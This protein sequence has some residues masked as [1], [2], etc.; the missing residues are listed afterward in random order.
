MNKIFLLTVACMLSFMLHAQFR[1]ISGTVTGSDDGQPLL[2]VTVVIEGT[3]SGVITDIDGKYSISTPAEGSV[4][5]FSYIGYETQKIKA[6][7]ANTVD[8]VLQASLQILEDVVVVGYGTE[9]K[10]QVTGS[11]TQVGAEDIELRPVSTVEQALQGKAA[12]VFIEANN[13]K[14]GSAMRIRIRGSSSINASNQPLFVVDGVPIN[15]NSVN[16]GVYVYLN[17]LNDIDFN[18]IESID[19]LKDAS[20]AAIYGSRG[21]NGVV[22]ITTKRG[23]AGKPKIT[24]DYQQ[25][26]SKPTRLREFMNGQQYI[27]Y[28]LQAAE[29]AGVYDFANNISGYDTEEEAIDKY[30]NTIEK[31]LD[32][33]TAGSDWMNGDFENV[34]WQQYAFQD[35]QSKTLDVSFSG[36]S[37]NFQYFTSYGYSF[38]D[39]IML[40]NHGDRLS[41]SL[42]LDARLTDKL[43]IG[44]SL[45]IARSIN[46]DIPDDNSFQTPLQIVAEPAI[47]PLFDT[48]TGDYTDVP[49]ALYSNPLLDYQY[50]T[51]I[52]T[53]YRTIGNVFAEYALFPSLSLRGEAGADI[54]NLTQFYYTS[55]KSS[56][57][58]SIGGLGESW[59][60]RVE[61]FDTKLLLIYN[62]LFDSAYSLNVTG[63]IEYQ[64]YDDFTT[65]VEGSGFP[66]DKL[67]TL[68]SA[69]TITTGYSAF[70]YYRFL[71]YIGRANFGIRDKY[72]FTFTGRFDGSSRFGQNNRYGFFPSGS[73]GWIISNEDFMKDSKYLSFLK[74]RA[75]YGTTGNAEIGNF[76]YLGLYGAGSYG[77]ESSLYPSTIANPDL[78]WEKTTQGNIGI[79]FGFFKDR[80]S[81]EIDIYN[82]NT[83]DLLLDV[84]VPSTSGYTLQTQNIG[85]LNNKGIE[86]VINGD[87]FTGAFTWNA[88]LNFAKNKNEVLELANGQ[89]IIDFG[90]SDFLNVVLVG[91]PIGV[92]YGAEYAGVDPDN[93][94]ALWYVN[95]DGTGEETTNDFIMANYVVVGDPNPDFI[96]GMTNTLTYK[97]ID[98][99]LDLQSVYGNDVNLQGDYWMSANASQYDNQ[100]V[101]Q[102]EAWQEPG[103]ITDVPENRL[104]FEN[105]TQ[106]RSSR[107][108]SD[109]SYLRLKTLTLG[110]TLPKT[111]TNK[112]KMGGLRLYASSYNL[113]T[114]TNYRG[115]DPEVSSDSFTDN[116]YVGIDFY[117]APQPKT[118]VFGIS[119]EL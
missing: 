33:L 71:S 86:L 37:E 27:D 18:D 17:P 83:E 48:V 26:W 16:D 69:A 50:T 40:G 15:T 77:D 32:K 34:D 64:K 101:D 6:G 87:I 45:Q 109:G 1:T 58:Q 11:I 28:Y 113:Y 80:L 78:T 117:S 59:T 9:I 81:G 74:L 12:G 44:N 36:G 103:D 49:T 61:N 13:G 79:D 41:G 5:V 93:G 118:I 20:A 51:G 38:Q 30:M 14:V 3:Q 63:G 92:F 119:A 95:G 99:I 4:L 22:I 57:G 97:G 107:Y 114:L 98:L 55:S 47:V 39:G 70:A 76:N 62:N 108:L 94:D 112:V 73:A 21:A 104:L 52:I 43:K 90:A 7:N 102:L 91:E 84:P 82:K 116:I 100:T 53:T 105:G 115:W 35:A 42:N 10:S 66:N 23:K 111:W 106:S 46:N 67:Q 85:K 65:L 24:V 72:L 31:K 89:D 54:T 68:A 2:G 8:V 88:N 75:S 96:A 25:G 19:I 60:A 110:Y 56:I 29:N